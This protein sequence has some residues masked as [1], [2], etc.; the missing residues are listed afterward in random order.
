MYTDATL[1]LAGYLRMVY[2]RLH[3]NVYFTTTHCATSGLGVNFLL[4]VKVKSIRNSCYSALAL[5]QY[6]HCNSCYGSLPVWSTTSINSW[7]T[8]EFF[9]IPCPMHCVTKLHSWSAFMLIS[10]TPHFLSL[11]LRSRAI[12]RIQSDSTILDSRKETKNTEGLP[13][14]NRRSSLYDSCKLWVTKGLAL[15][16]SMRWD[17]EADV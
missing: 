6:L 15:I 1:Q 16:I 7:S 5:I 4:L 2:T 14:F 13:P 17:F 3:E 10:P 12:T 8:L 11:S 9:L